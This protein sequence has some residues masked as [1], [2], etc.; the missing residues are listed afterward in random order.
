MAI[1]A[2]V[3]AA[4]LS[5]LKRLRLEYERREASRLASLDVFS[6]I[7]YEPH[8]KQREFHSATESDVLYGGS[9]G[10]GKVRRS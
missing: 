7:G 5:E 3:K 9:A 1:L 2:E 6:L 8:E 4:K 10:G